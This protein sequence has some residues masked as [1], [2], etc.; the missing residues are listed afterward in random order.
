MGWDSVKESLQEY[1]ALLCLIV[2]AVET[3]KASVFLSVV[4]QSLI[5]GSVAKARAL[6]YLM[7]CRARRLQ[8]MHR[9]SAASAPPEKENGGYQDGQ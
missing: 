7:L 4:A 5:Y 9:N 2:L 3:L 8:K 6:C 1:L